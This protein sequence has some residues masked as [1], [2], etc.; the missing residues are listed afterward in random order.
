[1]GRLREW[2]EFIRGGQLRLVTGGLVAIGAKSRVDSVEPSEPVSILA[3][4]SS[5]A[6]WRD[7]G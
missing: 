4:P 3:T 5:T 7:C 6:Q 1:M 2:L